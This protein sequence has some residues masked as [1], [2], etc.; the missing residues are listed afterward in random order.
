MEIVSFICS[1]CRVEFSYKEGGQCAG[2]CNSFCIIDL[3]EV[4]DGE[5]IVYFCKDCKGNR[6]G[7]R[8]QNQV[9]SVRRKFLK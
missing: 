8:G 6:Q 2:C 3:Y 7:K 9:V 4:L 1:S 5:K